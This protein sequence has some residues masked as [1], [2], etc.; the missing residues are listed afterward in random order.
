MRDPTVFCD[1]AQ[2]RRARGHLRSCDLGMADQQEKFEV[3]SASGVQPEL[4]NDVRCLMSQLR[5]AGVGSPA[6][7]E[8]DE[9]TVEVVPSSENPFSAGLKADVRLLMSQVRKAGAGIS[10]MG[11]ATEVDVRP[12]HALSGLDLLGLSAELMSSSGSESELQDDVSLLMSQVREEGLGAPTA[13]DIQPD[14]VEDDSLAVLLAQLKLSGT[15]HTPSP[16]PTTS[17]LAKPEDTAMQTDVGS[18]QADLQDDVRSLMSQLRQSGVE[19]V[20]S[21]FQ[22]NAF[23]STEVLLPNARAVSSSPVD[24]TPPE[25]E[26]DMRMLMSQLRHSGVESVADAKSVFPVFNVTEASE[27]GDTISEGKSHLTGKSTIFTYH[28]VFEVGLVLD[29]TFH[30]AHQYPA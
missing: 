7:G 30:F 18:M 20:T 10:Q 14:I 15:E 2:P 25:L 16:V 3:V 8:I 1:A 27:P 28:T 6:V 21:T 17:G 23:G 11:D 26:D 19:S 22:A 12:E 29:W 13:R 9:H 4:V 5:A 24:E